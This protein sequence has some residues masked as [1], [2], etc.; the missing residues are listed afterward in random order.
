M[1]AKSPRDREKQRIAGDLQ[2]VADDAR[3]LART[4]GLDPYP[5]NYWTTTR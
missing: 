4:L 3:A 5:V 2:T 1:T